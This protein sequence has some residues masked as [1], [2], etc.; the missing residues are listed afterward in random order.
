MPMEAWTSD[1]L[2]FGGMLDRRAEDGR[3]PLSTSGGAARSRPARTRR[4]TRPSSTTSAAGSVAK[5]PDGDALF[6]TS[7][8]TTPRSIASAGEGVLAAE[9][10]IELKATAAATAAGRGLKAGVF[11]QP[12][13]ERPA[14]RNMPGCT[15]LVR[16]QAESG[17]EGVQAVA[18]V[19]V[20]KQ[21]PFSARGPASSN[22]DSPKVTRSRTS[23]AEATAP[24]C[25]PTVCASGW[26]E[27]W[28]SMAG[29]GAEPAHF[30]RRP[31]RSRRTEGSGQDRIRHRRQ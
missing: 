27:G 18:Q 22:R 7:A 13:L 16:R 21:P 4:W 26:T 3:P 2:F 23:W 15:G 25:R 29:K 31:F 14:R 11:Q 20:C 10:K 1:G 24:S 30:P 28:S 8:G 17:H 5:L 12:R 6:F 9:R 19:P